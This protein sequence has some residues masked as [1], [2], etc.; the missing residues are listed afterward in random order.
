[1]VHAPS[2][3]RS[4]ADV[5]ILIVEDDRELTDLLRYVVTS[6]PWYA[7]GTLIEGLDVDDTLA[8]EAFGRPAVNIPYVD[9]IGAREAVSASMEVIAEDPMGNPDAVQSHDTEILV[10]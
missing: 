2:G 10:P 3:P 5:S 7:R 1:L 8:T 4:S 9:G 6:V